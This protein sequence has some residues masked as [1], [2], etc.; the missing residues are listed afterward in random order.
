M[1]AEE[2]RS[3]VLR[4]YELMSRQEF[5]EM[6]ALMADDATWT[7]AGK[8]A[9]FHHAGAHS[10]AQRAEELAGFVKVFSALHMDIRS[11]TAEDDRV[12]VEAVTRCTT[13]HGLAYENELLVLFR[14]R[15]AK[16][17]GIYEH[18]DQQTALQFERTL[19]ESLARDIP[20]PATRGLS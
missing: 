2:N 16:I 3:L 17:V 15:D 18:L 19:R 9:T 12:V 5:E 14:C 11:T 8:P 6:F 1:T 7:V 13:H 20:Q 10:K 4:F